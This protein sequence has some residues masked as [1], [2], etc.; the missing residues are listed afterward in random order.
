MGMTKAKWCAHQMAGVITGGDHVFFDSFEVEGKGPE[1]TVT[2]YE[3]HQPT[4]MSREV[5]IEELLKELL[6]RLPGR[7]PGIPVHDG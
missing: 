1:V 4:A 5:P 2:F 3:E 7:Y 6:R